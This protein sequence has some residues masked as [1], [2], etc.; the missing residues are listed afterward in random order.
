MSKDPK[1]EAFSKRGTRRT[2]LGGLTAVA[3]IAQT[4]FRQDAIARSVQA[5][6]DAQGDAAGDLACNEDYWT[7]IQRC[8]DSDRTLINLNN[9]GVCPAPAHVLEQMVRDLR[10]CNESPAYHMWQILEPRIETVRRAL[11]EQFGCEP[12]EIAITRNASEGMETLILG[13]DLK[14]GDEVIVTDQNYPR[15]LITWDQR[16]R[17]EGIVVKTISFPVPLPA[18]GR[19]VDQLR[20]A[21][22]QKTRVIEFPHIT[23]LTGQILPV[24][25]AV[26][27]AHQLGIAVFVDGA[28][29]FAQFPFVRD[30]LACD[31]FATSLH[32]WL[33]APIGTGFLY[34]RNAKIK[35]IWPLL[36]AP[37]SMNEDIRK[38]EEIGTHPA[39]NHNAIAAA[40]AFHQSIGDQRKATRLR[41]LRNRWAK[42]LKEASDRVKIWTS[43]DDDE[44]SCGIALLQIEGIDPAK[45]SEHLLAKHRIVTIA[46]NHSQFSGIRIT[47]NVYTTPKEIDTFTHVID[48]ILAQGIS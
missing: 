11:A 9:G 37:A 20:Q 43:L 36:A 29:S 16:A 25:D 44:A 45:L 22:T 4:A 46:I 17:R 40:L 12:A 8:F 27:L 6:H 42:P 28:H 1:L 34:V 26:E 24:R 18:P 3:T 23:N 10:F 19:F 15:M 32:K 35:S 21:I 47:P 41:Y 31:F 7:Q 38:Y 30:Q 2:F 39:A 5:G 48:R 33:L 13:I 14:R